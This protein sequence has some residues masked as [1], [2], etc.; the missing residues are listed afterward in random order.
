M[1]REQILSLFSGKMRADVLSVNPEFELMQEIRLRSNQPMIFVQ[2]GREI[3]SEKIV[4]SKEIKEIVEA[5][6]GHSG[7]AFEE[8]IR[9]GYLTVPGGHRIGLTGKAVMA[10]GCVQTLKNI[11]SLNI[12]IS[13]SAIGCAQKWTDYFYETHYPC[14]ML[15][16]SPPGCGK[17]TF[18]RDVIRMFSEGE[19]GYQA[20]TVGVVD[21]RSEIAGIYRGIQTH[22]LG[23][24]TDVLDG[25][26]KSEGMEMLLRSMA[27]KVLAVD[28]IGISDVS[29]IESVLRCGCKIIATLHGE[30]LQDFTRKPGF[31][32][33]VNERIFER[34]IFLKREQPPGRVGRIYDQNFEILWEETNVHKNHR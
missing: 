11:S 28:E 4:T 1:L 30:S 17:T 10:D 16:I 33:L 15:I 5:A 8:E 9:R 20:V 6:C 13:H 26:P 23:K 34:Y 3:L 7:Y 29:S 18:L 12:R 27:P 14:H 19:A 32:S 22:D 21:E 31:A 2:N 25:C 24:R